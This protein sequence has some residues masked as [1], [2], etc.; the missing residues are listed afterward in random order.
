MRYIKQTMT[1]PLIPSNLSLMLHT[2]KTSAATLGFTELACYTKENENQL[3][4]YS[5][6]EFSQFVELLLEKLNATLALTT[7][8]PMLKAS[9]KAQSEHVDM[10]R[11]EINNTFLMIYTNPD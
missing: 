5:P 6:A 8:I 4:H 10:P 11:L 2:L 1:T 3:I 7:F 9:L